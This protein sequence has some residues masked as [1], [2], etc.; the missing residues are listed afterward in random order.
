MKEFDLTVYGN[1]ILD[2]VY[3]VNGF[4]LETS[5]TAVGSYI[6]AGASGNI[7]RAFMELDPNKA[8][9]IVGK[10]GND[11]SGDVLSQKLSQIL[12]LMPNSSVS[13]ERTSEETSSAIIVSNVMKNTRTS[14]VKW[15]CCRNIDLKSLSTKT[16]WTHLMYLDT[17]DNITGKDIER[18]SENSIV[19]ADLCLGR[20]TEYQKKKIYKYL[21]NI[22]YLILSD[23]EAVSITQT[24]KNGV[25]RNYCVEEAA[26]IL[27][28]IVRRAVIIHSPH[29]S[30]TYQD[31]ELQNFNG[32]YINNKNLNVLGAGDIFAAS[33]I[34][35][36][37][38]E[39]D[40]H[41]S[42]KFAHEH[43]TEILKGRDK[44]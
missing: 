44:K 37:L 24:I 14:I 15:G 35:K 41:S 21:E 38:D 10:I 32:Q 11:D 19:S 18:L 7:L 25:W 39:R 6:D 8:V 31:G 23:V 34:K 2:R 17:L 22:D 26:T 43:T 33:F 16:K 42:I 36:M 1:I 13:L 30:T 4:L 9:K 27:G 20:H 3:Y 40:L 12:K 28:S 29:G 5:N